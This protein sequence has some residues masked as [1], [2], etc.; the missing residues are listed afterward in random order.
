MNENRRGNCKSGQI[1][2]SAWERQKRAP[3]SEK[4]WGKR[5]AFIPAACISVLLT[6]CSISGQS[7]RTDDFNKDPA[8]SKETPLGVPA[9]G[10]SETPSDAPSEARPGESPKDPSEARTGE[11][12]KDPSGAGPGESPEASSG[13]SLPKRQETNGISEYAELPQPYAKYLEVLEQIMAEGRDSN[14][15]EYYSDENYRNFE[16]NCFAILDV[17]GDGR[18][19]LIFNFNESSTGSMFEVVYEYDQGTDTL[20]EELADW[21]NTEYYTDGLV[22]VQWSHNHGR[23]PYERGGWPYDLYQYDP[24]ENRYQLLYVVDAWD[25]QIYEKDFPYDLD[26]DG[27]KLVYCITVENEGADGSMPDGSETEMIYDRTEYEA[28]KEEMM[29]TEW[30]RIHV[31]YHPMTEESLSGLRSVFDQAAAY[32]AQADTW[33]MDGEAGSVSG[34]YLLYDMDGDGDSELLVSVMQGTG[35]YSD[36]YFYTLTDEGSVTELPLVRMCN[37]KE[38]E[39]GTDFDIGG[40]TRIQA[41]RDGDGI[42]YYEGNDY[43]REGIYGL[44]DET[45]F[46]YLEEGV[47][48]QDSI[49]RRTQFFQ[50]GGG[51]QDETHYYKLAESA[52]GTELFEEEI[53]EEQFEEIRWKYIKDMTEIKVYQ[54]WVYFMQ[55][56]LSEGKLTEDMI[57]ERLLQSFLGSE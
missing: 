35:R 48:Y 30:G 42:V 17:D 46:Y 11:S 8:L 29:M 25:G 3:V 31:T 12:P 34:G 1:W 2:G 44:Y 21:V 49:R 51:Q 41:Y 47:V 19:E 53:T 43:T 26:A 4:A 36:N 54:N 52:D 23:D 32:A 9:G 55:E 6:A 24:E 56:E 5:A 33:L 27:D 40:R 15:R 20:W 14:G 10:V 50:K 37:G 39:W 57:C 28:W 38:R 18:Q 13:A 16:N 7:G 45:G 22:K